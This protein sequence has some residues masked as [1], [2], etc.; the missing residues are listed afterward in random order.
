[1]KTI[2]RYIC[3][4]MMLALVLLMI[5]ACAGGCTTADGTTI[6]PFAETNEL[7]EESAI[8]IELDMSTDTAWHCI[9]RL[10]P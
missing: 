2:A 7:R 9:K 8:G 1:M 6:K 10:F 5:L 3:L 4:A